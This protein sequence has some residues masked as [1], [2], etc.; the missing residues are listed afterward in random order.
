MGL[1]AANFAAAP[2]SKATGTDGTMISRE[3]AESRPEIAA[4]PSSGIKW[5]KQV[6]NISSQVAAND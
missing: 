4:K 1:G 5:D 6:R 2:V 3:V